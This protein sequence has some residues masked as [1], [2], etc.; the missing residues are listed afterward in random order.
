MCIKVMEPTTRGIEMLTSKLQSWNEWQYNQIVHA[1]T[2]KSKT[3]GG[4]EERTSW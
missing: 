1:K 3:W 4:S 2:G